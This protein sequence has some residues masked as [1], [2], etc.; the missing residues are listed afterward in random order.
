MTRTGP[1][2][3]IEP[4]ETLLEEHDFLIVTESSLSYLLEH[5]LSSRS[6]LGEKAN[7]RWGAFNPESALDTFAK[8]LHEKPNHAKNFSHSP[9]NGLN[10]GVGR[11]GLFFEDF[12]FLCPLVGTGKENS[13]SLK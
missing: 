5:S 6:F 8:A 11:G 10:R 2:Q 3:E 12:N 7:Y 9:L 4:E 1:V 13:P